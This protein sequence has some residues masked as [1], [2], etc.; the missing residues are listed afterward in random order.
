MSTAQPPR[1]SPA[2]D[3][4]DSA[5]HPILDRSPLHPDIAT[6]VLAYL[7]HAP[8]VLSARS[9]AVDEFAPADRDVPMNFHTDGTFVWPGAVPYNLRKYGIS[10]EQA[11]VDHIVALGCRIPEVDDATRQLA[12]AVVVG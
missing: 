8:V 3:G 6:D 10:P 2:I 1:L 4:R 5:G 11:L 12:V 9:Y 7:E